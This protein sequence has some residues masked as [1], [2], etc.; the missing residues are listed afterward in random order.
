MPCTGASA[1]HA[2]NPAARARLSRQPV[3]RATQCFLNVVKRVVCL[4][5]CLQ[6]WVVYPATSKQSGSVRAS[7]PA[8][9][10]VW[11]GVRR[12]ARTPAIAA[13]ER[14]IIASK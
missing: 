12:V 11:V 5:T 9:M 7:I 14:A 3:W 2:H 1:A 6:E 10:R 4:L 8:G 13:V